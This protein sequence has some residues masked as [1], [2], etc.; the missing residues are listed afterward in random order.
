MTDAIIVSGG[1]ADPVLLKKFL[2]YYGKN[3]LNDKNFI[4]VAADKGLSYLMDMSII[5]DYI[6]GDFDSAGEKL[7]EKA[8]ELSETGRSVL[9]KLNPIKDDTDTEA[10]L[11]LS[12][13]ESDGDIYIFSG[14][15]NRLDHVI[16]NIQILKKGLRRHRKVYLID[17]NNKVQ[18]IDKDSPLTILKD[19]QYG[20]FVSVFPLSGKVTGLTMTG[21]FYPLSETTLVSGTSLGQSNEITDDAGTVK[22]S[23]GELIVVE[24][25]D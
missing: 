4:I 22:V 2:G 13:L 17:A 8:K 9:K 23:S 18:V 5:P 1:T 7:F 24:A 10:A 20:K 3:S 14:T 16:S 15:G 25:R 11:E 12:F 21:F 6:I 19:T